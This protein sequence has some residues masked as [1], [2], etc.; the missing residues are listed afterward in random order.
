M[1][2]N[3]NPFSP[4]ALSKSTQTRLDELHAE[5]EAQMAP[6]LERLRLLAA[7]RERRASGGVRRRTLAEQ[8]RRAAQSAARPA[9]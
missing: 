2:K 3:R 9:P 6:L 1:S 4:R 5:V 8:Q 7:E